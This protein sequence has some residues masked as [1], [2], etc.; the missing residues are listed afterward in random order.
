M[1]AVD[2]VRLVRKP[3][4][5]NKPHQDAVLA[6]PGEMLAKQNPASNISAKIK[7]DINC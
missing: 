7:T 5:V 1:R 3:G 2:K 4:R 6:V